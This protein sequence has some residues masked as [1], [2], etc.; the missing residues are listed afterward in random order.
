MSR[1]FPDAARRQKAITAARMVLRRPDMPS[2]GSTTM[3]LKNSARKLAMGAPRGATLVVVGAG[4]SRFN[5]FYAES[6][7]YNGHPEYRKIDGSGR[8]L[9]NSQESYLIRY[10]HGANRWAILDAAM[11]EM[12]SASAQDSKAPAE[13][14]AVAGAEGPAPILHYVT[15]FD[16]CCCLPSGDAFRSLLAS[17]RQRRR[18]QQKPLALEGV[19]GD[20][21]L[22]HTAQETVLPRGSVDAGCGREGSFGDM[23]QPWSESPWSSRRSS[24]TA[25]VVRNVTS[26][27]TVQGVSDLRPSGLAATD[28]RRCATWQ[29][30]TSALSPAFTREHSA[31]S[32]SIAASSVHAHKPKVFPTLLMSEGTGGLASTTKSRSVFL[33]EHMSKFYCPSPPSGT[34]TPSV[35]WLPDTPCSQHVAHAPAQQLQWLQPQL[36]SQGSRGSDTSTASGSGDFPRSLT[37]DGVFHRQSPLITARAAAHPLALQ[38]MPLHARTFQAAEAAPA[39]PYAGVQFRSLSMQEAGRPPTY[40]QVA[41]LCERP[42]SPSM[43]LN[44]VQERRR[45]SRRHKEDN[46]SAGELGHHLLATTQAAGQLILESSLLAGHEVVLGSRRAMSAVEDVVSHE[47]APRMGRTASK[48]MEATS[49]AAQGATGLLSGYLDTVRERMDE[50]RRLPTISSASNSPTSYSAASSEASSPASTGASESGWRETSAAEMRLRQLV[51]QQPR[52]EAMQ[53]PGSVC[54]VQQMTPGMEHAMHPP[55]GASFAMPQQSHSMPPVTM[56]SIPPAPYYL[57]P[58]FSFHTV[59]ALP[60]QYSVPMTASSMR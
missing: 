26:R 1:C 24:P 60:P 30:T 18:D 50:H 40:R 7:N 22:V 37:H 57:E 46:V 14:W 6:G 29:P 49:A 13:S 21:G 59:S 9:A 15:L 56:A 8:P 16:R 33:E 34:Q 19:G 58:A 55:R 39:A 5:G 43:G 52:A 54:F 51:Q 4:D 27:C 3:N 10:R 35:G 47:L 2:A 31:G 45:S 44:G 17:R 28:G 42:S 25:P 53:Q 48:A 23:P 20:A 32:I 11:G 36:H 41:P 38:P 12:Y